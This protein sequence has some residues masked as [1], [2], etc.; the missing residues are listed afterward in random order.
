MKP[1]IVVF[2]GRYLP[3]VK[4]GGP[5]Q[6]I[7]NLVHHFHN[8]YDF[9]VV[10]LDRDHGDQAPYSNITY[11]EPN[12]IG[13][14]L[15]WYYQQK[16][17]TASYV[18]ERCKNASLVYVC[19]PYND[20]SRLIL[21][22]NK[23]KKLN[24]PLVVASMGSFSKGALRL[25]RGKK[26][27]YLKVMKAL[28]YF[29][30]MTWSV[31]SVHE[32]DDL[33]RLFGAHAR[34]EVAQDLPSEPPKEL[35]NHM[36]N[37]LFKLIFLSRIT[38]IKNLTLVLEVLKDMGSMPLVFDAYG[39]VEDQTYWARCQEI[40]SKLPP[41]IQVHYRGVVPQGQS[42]KTFA[43][44]DAFMFPTL[45]ENYGHVIYEAL[46]SGCIPIISDQTP[47]LDL[48]EHKVG[49]VIDAHN[50]ASFTKALQSVYQLSSQDRL[51]M[52]KR[53]HAYALKVYHESIRNS[54]YQSLF[55]RLIR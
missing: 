41:S 35:P 50:K 13:K 20:Y 10:C 5:I 6:T 34:F 11:D 53:A 55:N 25:K 24:I 18:L 28:G 44:Y 19:G 8:G 52:K 38:P 45:G 29:K 17:L 30:D 37:S 31:T 51:D 16:D 40:M 2:M 43:M 23:Q 47:W 27:L 26:W 9:E 42:L 21:K 49:F 36:G 46:A 33:K 7:V 32:A 48:D 14:A 22:L 54:G 12:V 1:K 4:D 39:P 3:G 15:V